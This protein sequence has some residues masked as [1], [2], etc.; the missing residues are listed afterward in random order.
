MVFSSLYGMELQ[1]DLQAREEMVQVKT[2][3]I[4]LTFNCG[5]EETQ[6]QIF[7]ALMRSLSMAFTTAN[8]VFNVAAALWCS[9]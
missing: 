3:L 6:A 1:V 8:L 5:L 7:K 2:T 4:C 9:V